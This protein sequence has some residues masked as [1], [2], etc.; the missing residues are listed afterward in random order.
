MSVDPQLYVRLP[1]T[2][3]EATVDALCVELGMTR[4]G[5]FDDGWDEEFGTRQFRSGDEPI[6]EMCLYRHE[7]SEWA[8]EIAAEP[9]PLTDELIDELRAQIMD[10]AGRHGLVAEQ[11]YPA[12]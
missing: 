7:V 5:R 11:T 8:I 12:P 10:A 1:A 9:P 2:I 3:D 6:A 4:T